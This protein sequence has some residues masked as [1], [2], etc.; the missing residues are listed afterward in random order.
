MFQVERPCNRGPAQTERFKAISILAGRLNI[1][2]FSRE[3]TSPLIIVTINK[4][5]TIT[6]TR[7]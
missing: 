4:S 1:L 5:I 7:V 2:H 6:H 3:N